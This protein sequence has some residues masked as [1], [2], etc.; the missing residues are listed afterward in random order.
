MSIKARLK[1]IAQDFPRIWRVYQ[2]VKQQY[3]RLAKIRYFYYDAKAVYK[4][5]FWG[6]QHTKSTLT[7]ALL[8]QYHKLEKG[9][10]M[11]GPY[12]F[13]GADPAEAVL[14]LLARWRAK[15]YAL[16]DPIYLGATAT[17]NAYLARLVDADLDSEGRISSRVSDFLRTNLVDFSAVST[18]IF[19]KSPP[20]GAS[21]G[22]SAS[23]E[24]LVQARR[25]VRT[26]DDRPVPEELLNRAI[27]LAQESPSACNRQPCRVYRLATPEVRKAAL[28]LQNGNRGFGHLASEVLV[29]VAEQS[30]YFDATERNQPYIDGG[31]FSMT[32]CY[33][34]TAQGVGSC[35]L[36]WC[37][38][39]EANSM[40]HKLLGIPDS[41]RIIMMMAV[42]YPAADCKVPRSPRKRFQDILTTVV[43][44]RH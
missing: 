42:G 44:T 29:I 3:L 10:V 16:D 34:L 41:E 36:N 43:A 15:Q 39:P 23:F 7:A 2:S 19:L 31:L 30:A 12:R 5:S 38:E 13:F 9:L 25:S 6:G 17:L 14:K 26:Y 1:G 24:E 28:S 27:E 20:S 32:L 4:Y 33:A 8:F 40:A 35:C 18:P 21:N 11:P 37:V 22:S